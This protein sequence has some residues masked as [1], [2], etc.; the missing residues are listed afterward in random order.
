MRSLNSIVFIV[1]W[2]FG[3]FAQS[4]TLSID[5]F[6]RQIEENHPLVKQADLRINQSRYAVLAAK[7]IFDPQLNYSFDSKKLLGDSYFNLNTPE[8]SLFTPIG[9]KVKMGME[10][11]TGNYLDPERTAGNLSY[12]GLE[13][14]L[15]KDLILDKKRATLKQ[16]E[17]F[18]RSSEVE[19]TNT[20]NDL[21]LSAF[22]DYYEWARNFQ[23]IQVLETNIKNAEER[24]KLT[25]IL[26]KNGD[27]SGI[28]TTEAMAQLMSIKLLLEN[29]LQSYNKSAIS[30]SNYIWDQNGEPLLLAEQTIPDT[31]L[32]VRLPQ[33]PIVESL[34]QQIDMHP[35]IRLYDLKRNQLEIDQRLKKQALMPDL[36]IKM[37]LLSKDYYNFDQS[38]FPQLN[39]NYKIGL[40]LNVPLLFREG[41]GEFQKSTLKI[42]E[43]DWVQKQKNWD[44][45]TKIRGQQ[46]EI[47]ALDKQIKIL[48]Q[49]QDN[50][51]TLLKLEE[52]RFT[53]GESTL[54]LIN[55]RQ[56]KLIETQLKLI[57]V[58]NKYLQ[59]WFKQLWA[60]GVINN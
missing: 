6:M 43:N 37:N 58:K 48:N 51:D 36:R 44:L 2:S 18:V 49:L 9:I 29:S 41:R 38:F 26:E 10:N 4:Q 28:D 1:L 53:Q 14:P 17:V 16:A 47:T 21:F 19:K 56:N 13:M 45:E 30:L 22:G 52:L 24:L 33:I 57:E 11:A 42:R 60:A 39:N 40:S 5:K 50:Y 25:K 34:I 27:K 12:F 20:I 54:F 8:L 35:L 32:L 23:Q 46:T 7:G 15:L 31:M 55:S 59:I 3:G